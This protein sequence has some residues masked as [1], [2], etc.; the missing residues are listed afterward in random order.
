MIYEKEM[1]EYEKLLYDKIIESYE[2]DLNKKPKKLKS[3][4]TLDYY[5]H[6]IYISPIRCKGIQH[7]FNTL[8]ECK[9]HMKHILDHEKKLSIDRIFMKSGRFHLICEIQKSTGNLN[10]LEKIYGVDHDFYKD[11]LRILLSLKERYKI[12][13]GEDY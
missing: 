1:N 11:E 4:K 5:G 2:L 8:K 10:E 7:E 6:P 3:K 12:Q 13:F 9:S